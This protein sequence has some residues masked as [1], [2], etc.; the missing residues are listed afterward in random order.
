ME[1]LCTYCQQKISRGE[2]FRSEIKEWEEKIDIDGLFIAIGREPEVSYDSIDIELDNN[3]YI[4]SN[5]KCN[6]NIDGVFVAGDVRKK[7]VR[8]LVTATSDGAIAAL[9]AIKY[10]KKNKSSN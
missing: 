5:D 8:Q 3:G 2:K 9:N 7:E 4:I 1:I 10:V 6:T